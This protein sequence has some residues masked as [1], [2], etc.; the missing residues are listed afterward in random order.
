VRP[1][2]DHLAERKPA[3]RSGESEPRDKGAQRGTD[4]R[5][6]G[7]EARSLLMRHPYMAT[8]AALVVVLCVVAGTI[9]WLNARQYESTDDAFIDARTV[10][11]SSQV[12]GAIVDVPVTDNQRIDEGALLARIDDRDYHAWSISPSRRSTRRRATSPTSMPRS[13]RSG[14][15]ST[16]PISR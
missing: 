4:E 10:S 11:I 16:R 12:G 6:K 9:W 7:G 8:A 2:R 14:R 5:T 1:Q 3:D 15:E 13:T